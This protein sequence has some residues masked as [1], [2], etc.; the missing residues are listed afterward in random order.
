MTEEDRLVAKAQEA[1]RN[2]HAPYSH[3]HV[4]AALVTD[5]GEIY[6]GCN[7]ESSS[8]GLTVCAERVAIFKAVSE[9]KKQFR[10]M[11]IVTETEEFCPPCGACRQVIWDFAP[12]L[13]IILVNSKGER[14]RTTIAKLY[15]EAFGNQF[16]QE[17]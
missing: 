3:F 12:E 15:P 16:L 7:V 4:G 2:A 10:K 1:Q 9:G 14:R 5:S 17:G 11:A 6:S 13:E 8:Y